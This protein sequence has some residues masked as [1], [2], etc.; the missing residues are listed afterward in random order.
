MRTLRVL[1]DVIVMW[2]RHTAPSGQYATLRFARSGYALLSCFA[3]LCRL[4][5][6]SL[7]QYAT[8]QS[9][10]IVGHSIV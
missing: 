9:Q 4:K 1:G 2:L 3:G 7:R 8:Q 6:F 10:I 5:A